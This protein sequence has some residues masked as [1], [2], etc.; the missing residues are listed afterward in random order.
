MSLHLRRYSHIVVAD[1]NP[2]DY[3]ELAVQA[4]EQM[5]N[6]HFLTSGRAALQYSSW[7]SV[8]LWLLN[9]QLPDI[10]GIELLRMLSERVRAARVF[11]VS[12]EYDVRQE[13]LA[14]SLGAGLYVCKGTNWNLN[15]AS[16]LQSL[17]RTHYTREPTRDP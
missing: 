5:W 12:D 16:L 8:D 14:C 11:L 15:C 17:H 6:V 7:E 13:R 10:G 4:G 1:P 9:T 3:Q 2:Q